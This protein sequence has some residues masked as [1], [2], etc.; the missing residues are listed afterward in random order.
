MGKPQTREANESALQKTIEMS[1]NRFRYFRWT[2]RTARISFIY[3]AV[4][5]G[6]IGYIGYKTDV[7]YFLLWGLSLFCQEYLVGREKLGWWLTC[8]LDN[9]GLFDFTAK[10][11]GDTILER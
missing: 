3:I 2:P 6:I 7:S 4:I 5:P 9:Q 10:Q 11:R 1:N 8:R